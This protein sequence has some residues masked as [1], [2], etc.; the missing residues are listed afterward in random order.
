M[1]T[2]RVGHGAAFATALATTR[3]AKAATIQCL[4]ILSLYLRQFWHAVGRH[5]PVR[6]LPV[7]GNCSPPVDVPAWPADRAD[8]P[9]LSRIFRIE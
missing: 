3:P 6:Q 2:G 7:N 4:N 1:V 5:A 9:L 8:S